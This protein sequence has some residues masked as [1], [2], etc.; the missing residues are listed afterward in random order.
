[1]HLLYNIGIY[2]YGAMVAI[3]ALFSSKAAKRFRGS[4]CALRQLRQ[5]CDPEARYVWFHAA[6]LGEFEQGRP[7]IERLRRKH[8]EYKI[9]LTFFSPSGY[10]VRRNYKSSDIVCYLPLDTPRNA[11]RFVQIVHP[12]KAIFIKYEYWGN[13]L[14]ALQ[15]AKIPTYVVSAIYRPNQIFFRFYGNFFRRLLRCFSTIFVQDENSY[16]LLQRINIQNVVIAGDTRFD[17]VTDIANT[18]KPLTIVESFAQNAQVLIAGS[19]WPQDE[20]LLIR[21]VNAN[22]EHKMII[23]PH[24]VTQEHVAHICAG[25]RRSYVRYTQTNSSESAGADCLIVDTVGLISSIYRYGQVAYIGGGFGA[26]IHNTLEAA[27][28]G[29]PVIFGP[30]YQKFREAHELIACGGGYTVNTYRKLETVANALF[31]DKEAGRHAA[32]YVEQHTGATDCIMSVI[33]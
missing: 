27:V 17:R 8:P 24:E 20:E 23:V 30:N 1:M 9:L 15:A 19:S 2:C 7:L 4:R 13:L 25:L 18:A 21:F 32:E 6:S 33:F 5:E 12:E 16:K 10:E 14:L 29:L 31:F 22:K 11:R 26:G 28:W 3:A